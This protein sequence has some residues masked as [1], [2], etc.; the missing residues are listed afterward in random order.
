LSEEAIALA[1]LAVSFF[2]CAQ[3][4]LRHLE[5]RSREEGTLTL[6]WQ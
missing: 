6:R 5:R 2:G 1:V 4:S 3:W